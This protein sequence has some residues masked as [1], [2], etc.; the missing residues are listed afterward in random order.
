MNRRRAAAFVGGVAAVLV[1]WP[2]ADAFA[3]VPQECLTAPVEGQKLQ[4]DGKLIEARDRFATC[5][6][7]SCPAEVVEDCVR[8]TREVDDALPSVVTAARDAAGRDLPDVRVSVDGQ[9]P[10][11]LSARAIRLD[12]GTHRF[13]FQRTGSADVEAAVIVREGEK[14]RQVV[15]TFGAPASQRTAA[16]DSTSPRRPVPMSAWLAG[17]VAAVAFV[18]FATFGTLG[19]MDRAT[20]HCDTG[21]AGDQKSAVDT[22]FWIADAALGVGVVALAVAAWLYL[23]RPSVEPSPTSLRIGPGFVGVGF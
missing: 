4:R 3:T 9:P 14:N 23:S 22:K 21:C 11:E 6:L 19:V 7:H 5:S 10:V 8:W 18:G 12:P 13:V 16:P 20:N 1:A 17:G 15:A 2:A